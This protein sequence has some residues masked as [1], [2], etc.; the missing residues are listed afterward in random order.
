MRDRRAALRIV[1]FLALAAACGHPE[2]KVVSQYFGAV[3]AKDE[4]TLSS[5][6]VV[7]FD[8]KVDAWEIT[9]VRPEDRVPAPLPDL[10]NK[11]KQL[12]GQLAENKKAYNAYFL[13]HPSEVDQVRELLRKPDPK[14]PPKLQH[15]ATEWQAFTQKEKELKRALADAKAAAEKEKKAV[16]LSVGDVSDVETLSGEMVSKDLELS[17]MI[18][19][20]SKPYVMTLR[21]YQMQPS[22]TGQRLMSRWVV[23][24][25]K[26]GA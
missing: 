9:E 6:A 15:Y 4:Q 25:L 3:N 8:Q 22:G 11:A 1:P 2:Q 13:E 5:F 18:E 24:S 14:I 10:V 19:G 21:K 20:A 7:N 17:L 26:A 12:E 23:H 16:A